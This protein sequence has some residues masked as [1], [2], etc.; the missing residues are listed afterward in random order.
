MIAMSVYEACIN[1][2]HLRML[3]DDSIATV[4]KSHNRHLDRSPIDA[5]VNV[6]HFQKF[7]LDAA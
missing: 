1:K 3:I 4:I 6:S 5:Q 2:D 7:S